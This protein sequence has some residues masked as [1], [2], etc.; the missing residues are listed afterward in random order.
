M[1]EVKRTSANGNVELLT[2]MIGGN[3]GGGLGVPLN[4]LRFDEGGNT[5][6]FLSPSDIITP[7]VVVL[8][9][10]DL[11]VVLPEISTLPTMVRVEVRAGIDNTNVGKFFA[12]RASGTDVIEGYVPHESTQFIPSGRLKHIQGV[13][14]FSNLQPTEGER[15]VLESNENGYWL[16]V[17]ASATP[18]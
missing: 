1:G 15:I 17:D 4:Y 7:T 14:G 12:V 13:I 11:E 3:D 10:D 6:I 5:Q 18:V 16:I 2:P 8:E 9:A